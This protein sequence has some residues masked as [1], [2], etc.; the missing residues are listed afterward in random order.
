M[1]GNGEG[2]AALCVLRRR[3]CLGLAHEHHP[4][5]VPAAVI[6]DELV[7]RLRAPRPRRVRVDGRR[8]VEQRLHDPPRLLDAVLAREA[9]ALP[10]ERGVQQ[11]LVGRRRPRRPPGELHV[12]RD[13]LGLR[14]RRRAARRAG[15]WIPVE[16]SSLIT[17]WSGSGLP[18]SAREAEPRRA[19]EDEP[20]LGLRRRESLPRA[21]EER[22]A[23]PAPAVDVEAQRRVGLG[24][25]VVGDAV[26]R[27]V[28]VVLAADVVGRVGVLDRPEERD[29]PVLEHVGI[30]ARGRLHRRRG[31]HLHE[32]VDDDVAQRADGVV[33]VP[34]VLDAEVLRH[35]DL[36]ALDV[37]PVPDRLE[38]RVREA[39][40]EDLARGPSS[41]GS[42]RSGRAATRRCTGA[43]RRRARGPRPGRG[44][45]ASRPRRV[46][47]FVRPGLGEALDDPCR[48]GRAGSRGRRR[49]L[50][51][52]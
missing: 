6:G 34:A 2:A 39:Q 36:H 22:H 5:A 20:D 24:R 35:G 17:N 18:A 38:H 33:E 1:G 44:R 32:V 14:A 27:R 7:G 45:T 48:R 42:G 8:G 26:D 23:R 4:G 25:R 37:V 10:T 43:A 9:R 3:G 29:H 28:A 41:R 15:S 12:E 47:V 51:L 21:D 16:G 31:D 46:P 50:R 49:G 52:P 40:V 30:A 11:H 13:R 19:L